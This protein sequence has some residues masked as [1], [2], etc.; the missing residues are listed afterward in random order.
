MRRDLTDQTIVDDLRPPSFVHLDLADLSSVTRA[1]ERLSELE[2][3]DVLV[4]NAGITEGTADSVT[5]QGIESRFGTNHL[6]HFALISG[7]LPSLLST[8]RHAQPRR[9]PRLRPR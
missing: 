8:P 2:S 1:A 7:L 4:A 6:G 3:L 9:P 5:K